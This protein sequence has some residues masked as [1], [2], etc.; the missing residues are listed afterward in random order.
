MKDPFNLQQNDPEF[1]EIIANFALNEVVNEPSMALDEPTRNLAIL[2]TLIGTQSLELY[3][4]VLAQALSDAITPIEAKEIVYQACDY[5]GF[6]KVYPFISATNAVMENKGIALP[7]Q[8]QSTTITANRLE[9]G[10]EAQVKIFGEQMKEA[11]KISPIHR[12]LADN[13]FGDYYTRAGLN[14]KQR[15]MLTFCFLLAQGGCESQL[16]SHAM[17]NMAL[18]NDEV[19]LTKV[20]AQCTPYI[21]YPRVL[22]AIACVN[23]AKEKMG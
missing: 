9:K 21:G 19:F 11:Y 8:G 13:C 18:G 2:A 6:G 16:T 15:E 17:G 10:V 12:W 23:Q 1:A 14:L 7:L 20:I 3:Q 22:N 4:I 5:L